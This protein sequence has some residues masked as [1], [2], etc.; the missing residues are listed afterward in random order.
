MDQVN[1]L[2]AEF[3]GSSRRMWALSGRKDPY[4]IR[5]K[6]PARGRR[7]ARVERM[8]AKVQGACAISELWTGQNEAARSA[9]PITFN[10]SLTLYALPF[11]LMQGTT[12]RYT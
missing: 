4:A 12:T 7:V 5:G 1:S 8:R 3:R 6:R 9:P 2:V 10:Q 11:T